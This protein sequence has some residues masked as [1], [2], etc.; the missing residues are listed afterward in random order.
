MKRTKGKGKGGKGWSRY[1]FLADMPDQEYDD[2]F[3]GGKGSSKGKRRSFAKGKGRRTNPR[4][5]DGEVMKCSQRLPSGAI[6]GSETHFRAQCPHNTDSKGSSKGS[7]SGFGAYVDSGPVGDLIGMILTDEQPNPSAQ[8]ADTAPAEAPVENLRGHWAQSGHQTWNRYQPGPDDQ[9]TQ[10]QTSLERVYETPWI[11]REQPRRAP[12]ANRNTS[13]QFG[14]PSVQNFAPQDGQSG[15]IIAPQDFGDLG[16]LLSWR[17]SVVDRTLYAAEPRTDARF[18]TASAVAEFSN[19]MLTEPIL[20]SFGQVG[21]LSTTHRHFRQ[22][23]PLLPASPAWEALTGVDQLERVGLP[24]MSASPQLDAIPQTFMEYAGDMHDMQRNRRRILLDAR[25]ERQRNAGRRLAEAN[26]QAGPTRDE[27]CAI[28]QEPYVESEVLV[29][30]GCGHMFHDQCN[31]GWV[32]AQLDVD[33]APSVTCC[34]CRAPQAITRREAWMPAYERDSDD[35]DFSSARSIQSVAS[36][37]A[38]PWWPVETG[39]YHTATQLQDGRLSLII[40][41]G[42]W[43][44]LMGSNLSRKLVQRAVAAGH[45]PEQSRLEEALNVRGVGNGSQA[46]NWKISLPI[47]TPR[48]DGASVLNHF[49]TPI[50]EGSG[51]ELPGLL[52]LKTLEQHRAILDVNTRQLHFPGPGEV[53]II[54]PPGSVSHPLEKAPSGHLLLVVDDYEHLA[55]PKRGGLPDEPIQLLSSSQSSASHSG[56]R[57]TGPRDV[58]VHSVRVCEAQPTQRRDSYHAPNSPADEPCQLGNADPQG[59]VVPSVRVCA[60]QPTQ[61]RDSYLAAAPLRKLDM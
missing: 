2:V 51:S 23:R 4:G 28:C 54:L 41:P 60:A 29:H 14:A 12:E 46:C 1:T 55:E 19:P 53:Q 26:G 38:L 10:R 36:Q 56:E 24:P 3:Y 18:G 33:G 43:T 39:V 31:D 58:A 22:T 13:R 48:V 30:L 17:Q 16:A 11:N 6:C 57:E 47:A 40:D 20:H 35:N 42:A 9:Q 45:R 8:P 21:E 5:R 44:N 34:I 7:G 15:P 61:R 59:V 52:G 49:T 32:A 50:V 27:V 25:A 37:L